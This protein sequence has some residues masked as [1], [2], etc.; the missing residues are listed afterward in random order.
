LHPDPAKVRGTL[1]RVARVLHLASYER[2]RI[3]ATM[4]TTYPEVSL[5]TPLLVDYDA[6]SDDKPAVPLRDQI[7]VHADV[8]RTTSP[9][10]WRRPRPRACRGG[11]P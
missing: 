9:R 11:R 7:D 10:W 1:D 6:W 8:A 4:A 5:F 2:A 3:A